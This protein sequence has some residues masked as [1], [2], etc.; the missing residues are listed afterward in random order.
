VTQR[1]RRHQEQVRPAG[2]VRRRWR[3]RAAGHRLH[4]SGQVRLAGVRKQAQETSC[5]KTAQ[6]S[7]SLEA[8]PVG[9]DQRAEE[10][11][12]DRL[13]RERRGLDR[14]PPEETRRAPRSQSHRQLELHGLEE[15]S[16]RPQ[17]A[18]AQQTRRSSQRARRGPGAP[19]AGPEKVAVGHRERPRLPAQAREPSAGR[20]GAQTPNET[21]RPQRHRSSRDH[22]RLGLSP[23]SPQDSPPAHPRASEP[24]R[25]QVLHEHPRPSS[26][27]TR[28]PAD[29]PSAAAQDPQVAG[30][31]RAAIRGHP[32]GPHPF[33]RGAE[34]GSTEAGPEAL[35]RGL[36]G[37]R[38]DPAS[39]LPAGRPDG[40]QTGRH[41]HPQRR[42]V[43]RPLLRVHPQL[44]R[45]LLALLRRHASHQSLQRD[46][47]RRLLR[48]QGHQSEWLHVFLPADRR[49]GAG[50][51]L[52]GDP[53]R[54]A[55]AVLARAVER[56]RRE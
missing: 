6:A 46:R 26:E 35:R 16:C 51:E 52:A 44:R 49:E 21:S 50:G 15:W 19:A 8:S 22:P 30:G 27:Q 36:V 3:V 18:P 29:E 9:L 24:G 13:R 45:R 41:P 33:A 54:A 37:R 7:A 31:R 42:G 56:E 32:S 23:R 34:E 53:E 20:P 10:A 2:E 5:E 11:K 39:D 48:R 25:P 43:R 28:R 14:P 47:R 1:L 55:R 12:K 4:R 17:R 40:L 38:R